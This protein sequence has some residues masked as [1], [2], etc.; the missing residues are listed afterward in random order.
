M[1]RFL[2]MTDQHQR[3]LDFMNSPI[4]KWISEEMESH[5]TILDAVGPINDHISHLQAITGSSVSASLA[6]KGMNRNIAELVGTN[7]QERLFETREILRTITDPIKKYSNELTAPLSNISEIMGNFRDS[8]KQT[9]EIPTE[10][11]N[12]ISSIINQSEILKNFFPE[13][14]IQNVNLNL[15]DFQGLGALAKRYKNIQLYFD[16]DGYTILDGEKYH[17]SEIQEGIDEILEKEKFDLNKKNWEYNLNLF[18]DFLRKGPKNIYLKLIYFIIIIPAFQILVSFLGSRLDKSNVP[19]INNLNKTQ[20]RIILKKIEQ[21]PLP[22]SSFINNY[23]LVNVNTLN[24]REDR[25]RKYAKIGG[26]HFGSLVKIL[27]KGKDWT[28]ISFEYKEVRLKGWVFSRY[29]RKLK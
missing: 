27:Y 3:I 11:Q 24:V 5:K 17:Y 23:R 2:D 26:L 8:L 15:I 29:L 10:T 28:L 19:M 7:M 14:P 6:L 12:L 1:S 13:S 21:T 9:I 22:K 4:Y 16:S 20:K 18:I 25:G